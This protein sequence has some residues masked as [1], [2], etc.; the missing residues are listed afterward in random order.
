MKNARAA[1]RCEHIPVCVR[2]RV[3]RTSRLYPFVL[4]LGI[5]LGKW[6]WFHFLLLTLPYLPSTSG[7]GG[8]HTL[9]P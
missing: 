8:R 7:A 4:R 6:V 3:R 2:M 1:A 5:S 9:P